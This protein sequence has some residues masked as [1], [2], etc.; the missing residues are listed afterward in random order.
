[1]TM[2]KALHSRDDIDQGVRRLASIEDRV[3]TSIQGLED[4]IYQSRGRLIK[5]VNN[6]ISNMTTDRKTMKTR[7]KKWEEKQ[8]YEYLKQQLMR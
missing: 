1:M 8:L 2:H 3:D 6:S 5:A 7:K 4:F